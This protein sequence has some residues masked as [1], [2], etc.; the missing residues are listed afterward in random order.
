MSLIQRIPWTV[1][2]PVGIEVDTSHPLM[3]GARLV[4][5]RVPRLNRSIAADNGNYFG[6]PFG[7]GARSTTGA[8]NQSIR[9]DYTAA[10]SPGDIVHNLDAGFTM[11]ALVYRYGSG[12]AYARPFGR[13]ANNGGSPPYI[14]WDFEF[15]PVGASN[16]VAWNFAN[17]SGTNVNTS[18]NVGRNAGKFLL[19]AVLPPGSGAKVGRCYLD[20]VQITS[21][22][23]FTPGV[24]T[25]NSDI[26][27]N[28]YSDAANSQYMNGTVVLAGAVERGWSHA[29]VV[30]FSQNPWQIFRPTRRILGSEVAAAPATPFRGLTL[31]GVGS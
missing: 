12:D 5:A 1:Q 16:E 2:P 8:A 20:G 24:T 31:L 9:W 3:R 23:S 27:I 29:E 7:I 15:N 17:S 28:G 4:W 6:S 14:N 26:F 13:T 11:F 19:V 10:D 18:A 25:T 30:S 21:T 22:S